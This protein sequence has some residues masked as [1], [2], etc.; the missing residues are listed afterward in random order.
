MKF[1]GGCIQDNLDQ[2][3][4]LKAVWPLCFLTPLL[5]MVFT[6]FELPLPESHPGSYFQHS[7]QTSL[8]ILLQLLPL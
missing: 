1:L 7:E 3:R 6:T 4:V 8:Q 5:S 2:A